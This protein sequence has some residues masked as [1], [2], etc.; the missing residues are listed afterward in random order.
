MTR[1][2][3][4]LLVA[5]GINIRRET[6]RMPPY[7]RLLEYQYPRWWGHSEERR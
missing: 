3:E 2:V 4:D 7:E 6:M 5:R 1:T